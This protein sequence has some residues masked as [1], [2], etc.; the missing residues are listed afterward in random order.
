MIIDCI[1]LGITSC[2]STYTYEYERADKLKS[3]VS[4]QSAGGVPDF[5]PAHSLRATA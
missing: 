4:I 2:G 1:C 3:L 5:L